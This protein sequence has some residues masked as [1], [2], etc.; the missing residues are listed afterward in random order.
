MIF[1]Q[2]QQGIGTRADPPHIGIGHQFISLGAAQLPGDLAPNRIGRAAVMFARLIGV[3]SRA[4]NDRAL[5][6]D[7][8]GHAIDALDDVFRLRQIV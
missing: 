7:A 2:L 3:K 1:Q 4:N 6:G 8:A 5:G